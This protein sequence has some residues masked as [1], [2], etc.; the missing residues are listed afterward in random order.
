MPETKALFDKISDHYDLLNTV[1][2]LGI[3]KLWR[4]E[5]ADT[6]SDEN[7]I[8]DIATG[9]AEVAIEISKKK[10]TADIVGI[11]PSEDMLKIGYQKTKSNNNI[12]LIQ[13]FGENLPFKDNSFDAVTIAF[14]I[15]NM[16]DY[17]Q[18]LKEMKRVLKSDGK[19]AILEFSI[20]NNPV[21]KVP[22]MIYF[23]YIMPSIS[24]VFGS[25]K[26]Y[27]YLS[28]SAEQFP[29]RLEFVEAMKTIGLK[30][31]SQTELTFG[32]CIIYIG[33]KQNA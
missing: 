10:K 31:I 28:E 27:K 23:K 16:I 26:E 11:D 6:V 15:R 30:G 7:L 21:F 2:S 3:D 19:V 22:Y 14:G 17:T 33:I 18:T 20:P 9:T 5:L 24:S 13:G 8:L 32:I 4:K 25:K 12:S 29:Q 1:F